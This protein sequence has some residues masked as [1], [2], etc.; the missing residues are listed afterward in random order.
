MTKAP[1]LTR[2][3]R[4]YC[5]NTKKRHQNVDYTTIADLLRT[6][7]WSYNCYSHSTGVVKPLPLTV[8]VV[9]SIVHDTVE[10]LFKVQRD[11]HEDG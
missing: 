3:S 2:K 8:K 11:F 7:S 9:K 4:K 1:T 10:I 6:V 5:D